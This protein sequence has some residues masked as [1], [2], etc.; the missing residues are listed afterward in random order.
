MFQHE[1]LAKGR[2][3][4]VPS[5]WETEFGRWVSDFGVPRIVKAL[6][7]DPDVR[8]TNQAVYEWLQGHPPRP[9][10]AMALVEL[11]GGRL[12]LEAIYEHGREIR[13]PQHAAGPENHTRGHHQR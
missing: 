11:S 9:A 8:V 6:A 13:R 3:R 12:T 2:Y 7:H 5:R 1:A 4:R 10:R